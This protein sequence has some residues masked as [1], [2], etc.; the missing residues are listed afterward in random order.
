MC[1]E[2]SN[3]VVRGPVLCLVGPVGGVFNSTL[4]LCKCAES[5]VCVVR[6]PVL[7]LV[8][9]VGLGLWLEDTNHDLRFACSWDPFDQ[10]L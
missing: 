4:I 10:M 5:S 9:P 2:S 6:G 7:C 3:C 8:G 1:A